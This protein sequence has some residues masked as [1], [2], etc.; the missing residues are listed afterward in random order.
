MKTLIFGILVGLTHISY[1]QVQYLKDRYNFPI[2]ASVNPRLVAE[3]EAYRN[4][5]TSEF[6]SIT[7][8]VSDSGSADRSCVINLC[9]MYC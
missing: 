3:N 1:G 5:A 2:G 7:A 8:D 6:N 9:I 4:V